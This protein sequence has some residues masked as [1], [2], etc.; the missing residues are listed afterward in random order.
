MFCWNK[1]ERTDNLERETLINRG[2]TH[3]MC[4]FKEKGED[5]EGES[6]RKEKDRR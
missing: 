6:V 5:R 1:R 3:T 2:D 4:M